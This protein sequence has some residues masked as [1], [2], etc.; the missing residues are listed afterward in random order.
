MLLTLK[1]SYFVTFVLVVIIFNLFNKRYSFLRLFKL[2]FAGLIGLGLLMVIFPVFTQRLNET[3]EQGKTISSTNQE[4]GNFTFRINHFT[5]RLDYVLSDPVRS[6]RGMGYIQERNFH[7]NIFSIG[8]YNEDGGIVQLDTGDIAWSLLIIRLGC[9]GLI[10]YLLFY[11]KC[12]STLYKERDSSDLN[13]LF[14]SYMLAAFVFMSFGNTV[15]ADSEFFI[16]PLLIS[17]TNENRT[18]HIQSQYRRS[19]NYAY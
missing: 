10:F 4:E 5:E 13:L 11:I 17:L 7:K 3:L 12:L 1:M 14:Y 19:R 2:F 6:I 15:I 9:L 16:I 18:L 8:L